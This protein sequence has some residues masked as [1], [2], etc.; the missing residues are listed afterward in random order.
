MDRVLVCINN[1][2]LRQGECIKKEG[3]WRL[4]C[5]LFVSVLF[6]NRLPQDFYVSLFCPYTT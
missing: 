5:T 4:P 2:C 3:D 6:F 1:V